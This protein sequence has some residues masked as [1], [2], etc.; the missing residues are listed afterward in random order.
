MS[1]VVSQD[2]GL[3]SSIKYRISSARE[4]SSGGNKLPELSAPI[5]S[6]E[7]I[8]PEPNSI[9][10]S[11]LNHPLGEKLKINFAAYDPPELTLSPT[12]GTHPL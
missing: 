1:T 12:K 6:G 7:E 9:P 10:L 11:V 3:T 2:S 4:M 8:I 5:P